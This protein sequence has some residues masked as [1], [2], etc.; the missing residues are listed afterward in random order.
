[1]LGAVCCETELSPKK[2]ARTPLVQHLLRGGY[3]RGLHAFQGGQ[4]HR[5]R[6]GTPE[7]EN[8]GGGAGG[9]NPRRASPGNFD[10]GMRY[11][12]IAG[13]VS[14]SPE[15][16][17]KR[18]G[19]IA[20]VCAAFG[21]TATDVII[22]IMCLRTKRVPKFSTMF[23]VKAAGQQVFNQTN[24]FVYP[25]GKV[26]HNADLSIE[27]NRRIRN[28][29]CSFREYAVELYDPPSA[30]LELE[31]RILRAEV[32]ETMLCG[33]VMWSQ[34]PCHYDTMCLAHYTQLLD[35]LHCLLKE[36]AH[37]PPGFLSGHAYFEDGKGEHQRDYTPEVDRVCGICGAHGGHV[38]APISDIRRTTVGGRE[39]REGQ[40]KGWTSR[41]LDYL[42]AFGINTD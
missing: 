14:Q 35:A 38:I 4:R 8:G 41:F 30:P 17:R 25:G 13:V 34:S 24:K 26:T 19:V 10:W 40:E 12:D 29:W 1:M 11:G 6:C 7:K 5:R 16:L 39:L 28:S 37:R 9:S 20:F 15:Q 18:M 22:E 21:L 32:L 2:G 36:Q 23:S 33:R 3:K 27:V 31:I 42:K